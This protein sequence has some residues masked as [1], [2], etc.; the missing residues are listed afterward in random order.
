LVILDSQRRVLAANKA[1]CEL[2]GYDEQDL[3]G[4]AYELYTHPDDLARNWA[5]TD[6]FYHGRRASYTL[7][8]RY[9]RKSGEA[10]WVSLKATGIELPNHP[11]P[12]LLASVQDITERRRTA[13]ERERFSQDLH[14]NILQS[15]YAIG[16]QLEASKLA[17]DRAPRKSKAYT[18][19][20]I[21]HLNR[22]V[23]EVRQFIALLR[24]ETAPRLDFGQA[25]RQLV[26]S[27]SPGGETETELDIKESVIAMITS[28]QGEQLLNIAREALSNSMRHARAEHRWIRLSR[29]DGA[30]RMQICDDGV[31]F[32][33]A[34]KR[35]PG[36]GLANMAARARRI[37][38]RYSLQSKPGQGTT[39]TVDLPME[40]S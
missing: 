5:L 34:R 30:I 35:K 7:E 3:I 4:Q 10:I 11:G 31:G 2:T 38:A 37:R 17:F 24:Q 12:L 6:E 13:E 16:M 22:L 1:F 29:V 23:G 18:A 20:A 15:L 36:H 8:K 40:G 28:E 39:I 26:A 21:E 33:P 14:D 19:R 9:V 25:L 27:F 32:I